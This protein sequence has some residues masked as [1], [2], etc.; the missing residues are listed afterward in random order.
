MVQTGYR[1]PDK[2]HCACVAIFQWFDL[3]SPCRCK[4]VHSVTPRI[5][6]LSTPRLRSNI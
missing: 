5:G 2:E 3:H 6:Q 1:G 4:E